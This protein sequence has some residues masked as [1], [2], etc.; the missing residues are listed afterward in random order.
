MRMIFVGVALAL[1][2][3]DFLRAGL[4]H[5]YSFNSDVT[6]SVGNADGTL[7]N[8]AI[9]S[10]GSLLLDGVDD[11]VQLD[12]KIVPLTGSYTVALFAQQLGYPFPNTFSEFISQGMSQLVFMTPDPGFYLGHQYNTAAPFE[13]RA[14]DAWLGTGVPIPSFGVLHHYA[15]TVDAVNGVSRLY[16]DGI[17]SA[18]LFS[19]ISTTALGSNTRFGAQFS[20]PGQDPSEY[21]VGRIDD[22]R[23]YD[24]A[25]SANEVAA[26]S[27][28]PEPS[29]LAL[30]IAGC[31]AWGLRLRRA[32]V[33]V[34]ELGRLR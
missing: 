2:P 8:G 10:G 32:R 23:I 7:L 27:A 21:F 34:G 3:V 30:C 19:S 9:V 11:Y 18:T 16:L 29:G 24:V 22:V 14:T 13:V 5:H 12:E 33:A 4:I 26:L 17:L 1:W 6:D 15:L 28:V 25:L 20:G 31:C